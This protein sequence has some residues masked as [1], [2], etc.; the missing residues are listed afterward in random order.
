MSI[1]KSTEENPS[2]IKSNQELFALGMSNSVG[3]MFGGFQA[4]SSFSRTAINKASGAVSRFSNVFSSVMI[5]LVLLFFTDVFQLLPL[6]VLSS[7]IISAMPGLM[8]FIDFKTTYQLEKREFLVLVITFLTTLE[9]GVIYGLGIGVLVSGGVFLFNTLQPHIAVLGRI[10]DTD[11]FKN[12][13][14]FEEANENEDQLILRIDGAIYFANVRYILSSIKQLVKTKS[15]LRHIIIHAAAISYVDITGLNE[16]E[17]FI[18]HYR[19]KGIKTYLCT[20]QGP[21]RDMLYQQGFNKQLGGE[22][23]FL[24]LFDTVNFIE[25]GVSQ[26]EK[27]ILANQFDAR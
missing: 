24:D 2:I 22:V 18:V 7:I 15:K 11:I 14:R 13:N 21:L 8:K 3:A 9:L 19:G 16:L 10:E 25:H 1:S 17:K 27:N 4:S 12:V 5:V 26:V 20:V 23:L 6:P